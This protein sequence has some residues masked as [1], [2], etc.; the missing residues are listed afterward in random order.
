MLR[1]AHRLTSHHRALF[2]PKYL[3][4]TSAHITTTSYFRTPFEVKDK[5]DFRK[6]VLA[7]AKPVLVDFYADWCGP[8]KA[9]SPKLDAVM[10]EKEGLLE[11]AKI[12]IDIHS[13]LALEYQ[14][15]GIPT[16]LAVRNGKVV[17][18]FTGL[19]ETKE[20]REFVEQLLS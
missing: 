2:S 7:S 18:K 5:D 12:D 8:C 20:L 11:L 17:N 13:D 19:I 14:V 1:M 10:G 3:S 6:K 4:G 16:V 9:L 15:T